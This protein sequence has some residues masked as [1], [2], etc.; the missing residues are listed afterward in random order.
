MPVSEFGCKE[1]TPVTWQSQVTSYKQQEP[2]LDTCTGKPK[3]SR[4]RAN[5]L[6]KQKATNMFLKKLWTS[7]W[8]LFQNASCI[9]FLLFWERSQND[10]TYKKIIFGYPSVLDK[11]T[12]DSVWVWVNEQWPLCSATRSRDHMIWREVGRQSPWLTG[13]LSVSVNVSV[14]RIGMC[15]QGFFSSLV[16]THCKICS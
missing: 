13:W 1:R 16:C 2:N 5:H 11:V 7:F 15:S 10:H 8:H 3:P 4:V 6:M 9:Y 12:P 14:S